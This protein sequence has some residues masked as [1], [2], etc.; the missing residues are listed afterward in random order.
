MSDAKL[1]RCYQIAV[2][3]RRPTNQ[4]TTAVTPSRFGGLLFCSS[5]QLISGLKCSIVARV[6]MSSLV[7]I[8]FAE[9]RAVKRLLQAHGANQGAPFFP[10][11]YLLDLTSRSIVNRPGLLLNVGNRRA[12]RCVVNG[13][14]EEN[15]LVA[16]IIRIEEWIARRH[17]NVEPFIA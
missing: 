4:S 13:T 5:S 6:E 11:C 17:G 3:Q 15:H 10:K 14:R 1:L 8:H 7:V 16:G 9:E 2:S 12:S